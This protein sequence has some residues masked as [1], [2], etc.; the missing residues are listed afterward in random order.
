MLLF[1]WHIHQVDVDGREGMF[2]SLPQWAEFEI[3]EFSFDRQG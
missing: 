2:S 1:V 3:L